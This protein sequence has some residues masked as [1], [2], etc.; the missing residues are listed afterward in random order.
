VKQGEVLIVEDLSTYPHRT[1]IEEDLLHHGLHNVVV[2]PL[3]YQ[4]SLIGVLDLLSPHPGDLHALNTMKLR[5]VLPLFAMAIHRSMEE[6]NTRLQAI[7]K[8]QCTAI[9]PAVEWRFRQAAMR[10]AEQR[11]EGG[12]AE[13]E[14]IVFDEVYPLYGVSD[15]RGSSQLRNAAIQADVTEHLR[16]VKETLQLAYG[17]KP[18]PILDELAFHVGRLTGQ[19]SAGLGAGDELGIIDF[20]HREVEPMFAHL[21][22]F[23][24]EVEEKIE[25]YQAILEPH[26]GTIYRR[27]KDF[28]ES[29]TQINETLSA[30]L[31]AEQEKAQA[32][33]P[34]YFE[35]HK[36]DGVE[37]GIYIGASMVEDGAFDPLYLHNLR[38]WQLMVMCGM[39]RLSEQIKGRLKVPLEVAHLILVQYTPLAVR[40]RLDEK[41]FDID[42]AYNMRYEIVK[43]RIDKAH[44][45]GSDERLT[46]PG[47]VAIVYS[48]AREAQE[49]REY[50]DYLQTRGQIIGEV[51]A[52]EIEDLDGAQGLKA[53]RV[54]V[55][56]RLKTPSPLL[57]M[58]GAI[59]EIQTLSPATT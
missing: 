5:E 3:Y 25:S 30:Y 29:V 22:T 32:M 45:K 12:T 8:E 38:L 9:H 17:C 49:Y 18:L 35:K 57:S 37:Y 53:L 44:I 26:L 36:S 21:R 13:L 15:I 55:D 31:D 51:E 16:L 27:R 6:L 14:P 28:E 7:I 11:Q 58:D 56:M 39:A 23:G 54:T 2:A 1:G 41:R 52:V 20:L 48:Q 34:H 42:G 50:I 40:F 33:F 10:W 59:E 47:K 46:Q 19:L 4:D 43:K 24:P